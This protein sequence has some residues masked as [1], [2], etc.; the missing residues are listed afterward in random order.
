MF[1]GKGGQHEA[2]IKEISRNRVLLHIGHHHAEERES[3]LAVT[4]VQGISRGSRM[5]IVIQKSTELGVHRITPLITE[6]SVVKLNAVR[7]RKRHEHWLKISHSACE[8]CG[9]NIVP[10][11]EMPLG[12]ADWLDGRTNDNGARIMLHPGSGDS[13]DTLP[14]PNRPVELLVGP[15]GGLGDTER[16]QCEEAGF[17]AVTLGPRTLRTETAAIAG[18]AVIQALWGDLTAR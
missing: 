1:D 13:I 17:A 8:Q 6:F 10:E 14:A 5:D 2:I 15:E 3:P 18:L 16:R 12:L 4:L 9:R 11:I 7:S